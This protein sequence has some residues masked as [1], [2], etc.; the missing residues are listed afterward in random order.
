MG[1]GQQGNQNQYVLRVEAAMGADAAG[2]EIPILVRQA[3][4]AA[5]R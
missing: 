3:A 4:G 2:R 1:D 5:G